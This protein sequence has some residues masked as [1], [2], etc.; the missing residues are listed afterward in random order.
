VGASVLRLSVLVRHITIPTWLSFF[1]GHL[2][3]QSFIMPR[4]DKWYE[5]LISIP[6]SKEA[7]QWF[8][9]CRKSGIAMVTLGK[10]DSTEESLALVEEGYAAGAARV[11]AVEVEDYPDIPGGMQ[12]TSRLVVTLPDNPA[13][14]AKT[15][16]WTGK[17][18]EEQGFD[19]ETDIGQRYVFIFFD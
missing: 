2:R 12:T 11:T 13:Q 10:M 18:A 16:S 4:D 17:V 5:S 1:L 15:L 9:T 6:T 19:P 3:H 7:R 14:R 8:Q